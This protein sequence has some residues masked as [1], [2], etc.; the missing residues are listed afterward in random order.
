MVDWRRQD[1]HPF[2]NR[3]YDRL[4]LDK[5]H[6]KEPERYK[7]LFNDQTVTQSRSHQSA[8]KPPAP[9]TLPPSKP[10][11]ARKG[12]VSKSQQFFRDSTRNWRNQLIPRPVLWPQ[13]IQIKRNVLIANSIGIAKREQPGI[14]TSLATILTFLVRVIG[15]KILPMVPL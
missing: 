15:P 11:S 1:D 2:R 4:G 14:Y 7:G 9:E 5:A 3:A 13:W 6:S 10:T 8:I 12:R